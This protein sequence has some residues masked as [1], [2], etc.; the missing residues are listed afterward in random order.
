MKFTT[1]VCTLLSVVTAKTEASADKHANVVMNGVVHKLSENDKSIINKS[2]VSAYKDVSA[3]LHLLPEVGKGESDVLGL[4]LTGE[5]KALNHLPSCRWCGNDDVLDALP[6]CRWCGNDDVLEHLPSCR[7][8]G[9]DDVL[10]HLPSC[11]WCG[12]DDALHS[13]RG[14]KAVDSVLH[15][16]NLNHLPSCRWCGND[17]ILDIPSNGKDVAE[18]DALNHLP[19][20]RWCG[21]DDVLSHDEAASGMSLTKNQKAF[22]HEVFEK[23]F[24]NKLKKSGADNFANVYGCAVHFGSSNQAQE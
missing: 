23:T 11:R 9:N 13:V 22:V 16:D 5:E 21:N 15:L 4:L 12:N 24:C 3:A 1:I 10:N 17:D 6:S 14:K 19:S 20:C 7:W 18:A 2:I 8:C